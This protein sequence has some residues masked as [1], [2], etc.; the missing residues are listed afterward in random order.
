MSKNIIKT[1]HLIVILFSGSLSGKAAAVEFD[2]KNGYIKL[3]Y[4]RLN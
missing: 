2:V 4:Y 1:N 3:P